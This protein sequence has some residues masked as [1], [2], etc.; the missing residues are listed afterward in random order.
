M[1]PEL[2]PDQSREVADEPLSPAAKV[3]LVLVG[4]LVAA[5]AV[6]YIDQLVE[7]AKEIVSHL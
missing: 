3:G 1:S 4:G 5:N 6:Y 7:G 2:N